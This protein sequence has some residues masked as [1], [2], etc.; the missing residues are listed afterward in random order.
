M[1]SYTGYEILPLLKRM[2]HVT[3]EHVLLESMRPYKR[4]IN[5]MFQDNFSLVQWCLSRFE[6]HKNR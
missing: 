1:R 5:H 6:F 2:Q 3:I 4:V